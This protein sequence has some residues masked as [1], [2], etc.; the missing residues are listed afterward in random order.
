MTLQNVYIDFCLGP[1]SEAQN[2]NQKS[3]E[4]KLKIIR[5]MRIGVDQIV[6]FFFFRNFK[7]G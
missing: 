4:M 5:K 2:I 6:S 3:N 7:F 1:E